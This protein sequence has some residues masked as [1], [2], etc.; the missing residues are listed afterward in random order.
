MKT[1]WHVCLVDNTGT[2]TH[3]RTH[4]HTHTHLHKHTKNK[5]PPP[6][7]PHPPLIYPLLFTS[8]PDDAAFFRDQSPDSTTTSVRDVPDQKRTPRGRLRALILVCVFLSVFDTK[9]AGA[10][11]RHPIRTQYA[12]QDEAWMLS[13]RSWTRMYGKR[14]R[15]DQV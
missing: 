10:E 4:T 11:V 15:F 1:N 3:A 2:H 12:A 13:K 5:Q 8:K 9:E 14:H 6:P 7:L